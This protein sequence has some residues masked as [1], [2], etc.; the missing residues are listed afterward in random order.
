MSQEHL[1]LAGLSPNSTRYSDGLT[2]AY[3]TTPK[4]RRAAAILVL[5]SVSVVVLATLVGIGWLVWNYLMENPLPY[6]DPEAITAATTNPP[7]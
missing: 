4:W 5:L 3:A 7:R 6:R 2:N 1:H